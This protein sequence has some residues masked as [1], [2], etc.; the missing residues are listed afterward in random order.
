METIV[1]KSFKNQTVVMDDKNYVQCTFTQCEIVYT[2]GD[3]SW[4]NAQFQDCK[5]TITGNAGKT[6]AFM[7]QV[8]ILQPA[9]QLL[10]G[11]GQMPDAG[12]VH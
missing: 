1:G 6:L 9:P 11:V 4:V 5:I 10:P 8:G 7:Q 3:F 12:G 2:G